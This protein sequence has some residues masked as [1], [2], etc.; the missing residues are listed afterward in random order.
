MPPR[1]GPPDIDDRN[2]VPGKLAVNRFPRNWAKIVQVDGKSQLVPK[3]AFHFRQLF[4]KVA[5]GA[6]L[7]RASS[8]NMLKNISVRGSRKGLRDALHRDAGQ[9]L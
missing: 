7:K 9:V 2:A 1:S 4:N 6:W 3:A 8:W 5:A